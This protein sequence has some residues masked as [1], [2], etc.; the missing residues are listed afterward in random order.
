MGRHLRRR[1]PRR[2]D[3]RPPPPR[4]RGA[5]HKRTELQAQRPTRRPPP[6][7]RRTRQPHRL[8]LT[9]PTDRC[10][11]T[12]NFRWPSTDIFR[13]L[14][15]LTTYDLDE[16]VFAALRAGASG[17]LLKD[18]PPEEL[19][20]AIGVVVGGDALLSPSITRRLV[21]EFARRP[22][23]ESAP[24]ALGELTPRELEV[25]RLVA[26]GRSNREVADI[27]V[28]SE[29]T[30]KTHVGSLLAKLGLRDRVQA[31]VFAYEHGIVKP[32][33]TD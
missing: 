19:L 32:G 1:S 13:W 15:T 14:L 12:D 6:A 2:R 30:V 33:S 31:V 11:S 17:F 5:D 16:Y 23:A 27:L 21:E 4:R 26:R 10:S 29:A 24:S 18:R 25:L 20:A 22:G 28:I 7:P 8:T 3:P 9:D